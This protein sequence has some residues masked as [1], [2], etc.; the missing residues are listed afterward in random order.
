MF[1]SEDRVEPQNS[2]EGQTPR[3]N[4]IIS[5]EEGDSTRTRW[6]RLLEQSN[7]ADELASKKQL[8][9]E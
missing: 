4:L 8:G 3:G 1:E 7:L 5:P 2:F 9:K 6:I